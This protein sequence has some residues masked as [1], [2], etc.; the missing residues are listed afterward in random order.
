[1][2]GWW[3]AGWLWRLS[4]VN[5]PWKGYHLGIC[6]SI[7]PNFTPT[8][9]FF[10]LS[11]ICHEFRVRFHGPQDPMPLSNLMPEPSQV[12]RRWLSSSILEFQRPA[13]DWRISPTW[14]S[15]KKLSTWNLSWSLHSLWKFSSHSHSAWAHVSW[16][17]YLL[18][19][20]NLRVFFQ[21]PKIK[22]K[23]H[24]WNYLNHPP[25]LIPWWNLQFSRVPGGSPGTPCPHMRSWYISQRDR[26]LCLG[27][28][29]CGFRHSLF[30]QLE[31]IKSQEWIRYDLHPPKWPRWHAR[32]TGKGIHHRWITDP[33]G[34]SQGP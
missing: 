31:F 24:I 3:C 8:S 22:K 34:A 4:S 16:R 20:F 21:I 2:I 32:V 27:L 7:S 19:L 25:F 13:L 9:R 6:S 11:Q 10:V 28:E 29:R 1:M 26:D 23:E 5:T 17:I 18:Y 33:L 12:Q 30:I 14:R 15:G